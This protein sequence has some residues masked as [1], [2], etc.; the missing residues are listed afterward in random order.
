MSAIVSSI[1][2]LFFRG[3]PLISE[4]K[5]EEYRMLSG[6]KP[7]DIL[8]IY[9]SFRKY[10]EGSEFLSREVFLNIEGI[11]CNPL[12]DRICVC[13]GFDEEIGKLDFV[14]YLRGLAQFNSPGK[15]DLKL[16]TAFKLQDF[17]DDGQI[18]K[19]DL[20]KYIGRISGESLSSEEIETVASNVLSES[21][22]DPKQEF[23]SFADFQRV[24]APSDFQSKLLL[25]I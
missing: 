3:E 6:F 14:G 4:E 18:N 11:K 25:P 20:I 13:F 15:R 21:S 5:M 17:D 9:L 8:R 7:K 10:T 23:L 12:K 19:D 24:V 16:K 2:G 22:S 1:F